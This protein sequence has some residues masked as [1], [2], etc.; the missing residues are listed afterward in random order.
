MFSFEAVSHLVESLSH[1]YGKWQDFECQMMKSELMQLD[2][3]GYGRVPLGR[4]Y[5]QQEHAVYKFGESVEY[6]RTIGALDERRPQDPQ[7]IIANYL[8]GPSNCV[9]GS[10]YYSVCCLSEC[11]GLMAELEEQI[12]APSA[13]PEQVTAL[14]GNLSSSTVEGPRQL[15]KALIRRLSDIA[16]LHGGEVPLHGRLFA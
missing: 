4:F 3:E 13:S 2:S 12:R 5:T 14:V 6:L 1:S 10:S 9:A 7:V 11:E 16:T 15:P 8:A